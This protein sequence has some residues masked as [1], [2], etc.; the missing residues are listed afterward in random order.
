MKA[1][2]L[3]VNQKLHY[4]YDFHNCKYIFWSTVHFTRKQTTDFLLQN[5]N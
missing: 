2:K 5:I 4:N 1:E 3:H